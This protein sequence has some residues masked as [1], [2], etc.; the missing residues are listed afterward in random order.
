MI[1]Q[2]RFNEIISFVKRGLEDFSVSRLKSKM[3]WGIDVPDDPEQ[4]MYVWFDA[5]IYY[6]SSTGWPEKK[7]FDGYWPGV[8]VAGKDN[9]RQQTAIWQAMLMSAGLPNSKQ[10]YIHGFIS[11]NGQKISKSLGNVVDPY[12]LV[13]TYGT[14][15]VRYYLLREIPS[16]DDGDYSERRFKELYNADLANG[17]GNLAA[18]V[19]KLCETNRVTVEESTKPP[20]LSYK[21]HM[22]LFE[23]NLALDDIWQYIRQLDVQVNN[24]E[25]WKLN[26]EEATKRLVTYI[27]TIRSIGYKLQPFLP[28][29]AGKILEQF[30]GP[31]IKAQSPLFPRIT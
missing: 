11:V 25:P 5:L 27:P 13:K 31:T 20:P 6:I 15:A 16:Y 23:F 18:R 24:D 7:D 14:D 17:L 1:P 3:P 26:T 2:Y 4:V 21:N 10:I 19:A 28:E 12:A 9:L 29:T 8:Q 30:K 22:D